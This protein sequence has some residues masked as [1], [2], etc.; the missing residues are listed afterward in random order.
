MGKLRL[1]QEEQVS[2]VGAGLGLATCAFIRVHARCPP[3]S[4]LFL[5]STTSVEFLH[6]LLNIPVEQASNQQL[7]LL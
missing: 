4:L 2:E 6:L 3:R 1:Q 7:L 5:G